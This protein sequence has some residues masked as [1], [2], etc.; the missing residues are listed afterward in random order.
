MVYK[1]YEFTMF[2]RK[3]APGFSRIGKPTK[4]RDPYGPQQLK[5]K[6]FVQTK[7]KDEIVEEHSHVMEIVYKRVFQAI[8]GALVGAF[9][10]FQLLQ[11]GSETYLLAAIGAT[12]GAMYKWWHASAAYSNYQQF[13]LR[14]ILVPI[15]DIREP[16]IVPHWLTGKE[17]QFT[18]SGE[19]H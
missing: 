13:E 4:L 3:A 11:S 19:K 5:D 1:P 8:L 6:K 2:L 15:E 16:A 7:T 9:L 18:P 17:P 10:V 12:A 14:P